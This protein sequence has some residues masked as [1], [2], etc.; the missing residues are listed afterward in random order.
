MPERAIQSGAESAVCEIRIWESGA[1]EIGAVVL[2]R[3]S[4]HEFGALGELHVVLGDVD[5]DARVAGDMQDSEE[6]VLEC[7]DME[8][9]SDLH[10]LA[11]LA[12][13]GGTEENRSLSSR[14]DDLV[15]CQT[16]GDNIGLVVAHPVAMGRHVGGSTSVCVPAHLC[17]ALRRS[18][19]SQAC[20][21]SLL[22]G[23]ELILIPSMLEAVLV[24]SPLLWGRPVALL[25]ILPRFRRIH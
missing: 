11:R 17:R 24:G 7:W 18:W 2:H 5:F 21:S 3:G 16:N 25:P 9:T 13:D 19:R 12:I 10:R 15:V 6:V 14:V 8:N 23:M 4:E 20:V 1:I 22:S